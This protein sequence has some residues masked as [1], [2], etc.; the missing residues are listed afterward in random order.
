MNSRSRV[1]RTLSTAISAPANSP[2]AASNATT[3]SNSEP[4]AAG[5][6]HTRYAA[7]DVAA[8]GEQAQVVHHAGRREEAARRAR[9][10]VDDRAPA[11]HAGGR[12]RGRA[13][14]PLGERRV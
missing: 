2:L 3:I 9:A 11:S 8:A 12:G 14:R 1:L 10:A 5:A 13:G 6:E 4:I 7:R